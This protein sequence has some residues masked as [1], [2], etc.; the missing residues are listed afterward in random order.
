MGAAGAT[1]PCGVTAFDCADTGPPPF[2]LIAWTVKRYVVPVVRPVI[3]VL[4]TGGVPV[5]VFGV[6][7]VVPTY[8][9]ILYE[10]TAP[11]EDGAVQLTLADVVPPATALTPETA[12]GAEAGEKTTS[13]Q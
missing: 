13:T 1:A 10:V 2:G 4:V 7:A 12:P 8:G 5:I 9:V 11:P 3:V 6:C